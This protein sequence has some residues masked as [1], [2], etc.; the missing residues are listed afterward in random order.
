MCWAGNAM[1]TE[2]LQLAYRN[3]LQPFM[4]PEDTQFLYQIPPKLPGNSVFWTPAGGER[5]YNV[6]LGNDLD[7]P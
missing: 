2:L 3:F 4:R 5:R 6:L 1:V 7:L